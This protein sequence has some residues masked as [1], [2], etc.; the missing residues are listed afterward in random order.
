MQM[1]FTFARFLGRFLAFKLLLLVKCKVKRRPKVCNAGDSVEQ[2]RPVSASPAFLIT[3]GILAKIYAL[4][5]NISSIK[6]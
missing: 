5:L 4:G 2:G 1:I 3:L 6:I